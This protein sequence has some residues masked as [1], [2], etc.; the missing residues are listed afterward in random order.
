MFFSP[1][2]LRFDLL[3]NFILPSGFP[4]DR[5]REMGVRQRRLHQG[6][7]GL[8]GFKGDWRGFNPLLYKFV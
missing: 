1:V 5:S 8:K 7:F 6:L 3:A 4:E 2:D